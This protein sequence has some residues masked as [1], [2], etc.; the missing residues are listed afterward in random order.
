MPPPFLLME[1]MAGVGVVRSTDTHFFSQE[2]KM[3]NSRTLNRDFETIAWGMLLVWW[4]LRWWPLI[5]LPEGTGLLGTAL[6][7]LGLNAARMLKGIRTNG[8]TTTLG[9]LALVFGGLLLAREALHL[10]FEI[11]VFEILLIGL[12]VILLARELLRV[13]KTSPGELR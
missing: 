4:G 1:Q 7:L 5:S 9:S 6:I 2:I 10:P 12:G 8:F 3:N 13:R 11:P